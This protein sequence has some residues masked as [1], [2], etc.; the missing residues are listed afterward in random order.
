MIYP[1]GT[2][3]NQLCV[4][5]SIEPELMEG[6]PSAVHPRCGRTAASRDQSYQ[7]MVSTA[8][9]LKNMVSITL[10]QFFFTML[11]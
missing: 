6:R 9:G 4:N 11:F 5:W 7:N 10:G 1:D 2:I 3:C 8:Y